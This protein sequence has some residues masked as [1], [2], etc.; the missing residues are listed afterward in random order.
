MTLKTLIENY[1]QGG[2]VGLIILSGLIQVAPIKLNPWSWLAKRIGKAVNGE[3]IEHVGN[4]QKALN[5]HIEDDER[6]TAINK[7][8]R[9][10]RYADEVRR[11]ESH[12]KS[13]FD[14]IIAD[15]DAYEDYCEKHPSF[16][17]SMTVHASRLIFEKYDSLLANNDFE[18]E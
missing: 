1:W 3:V 5:K 12:T 13:S 16:R 8:N 14:S 10:L 9:I 11:G 4:L 2:L 17:N 7:R 15:I 6:E 18:K